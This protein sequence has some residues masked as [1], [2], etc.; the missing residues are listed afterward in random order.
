MR[1]AQRAVRG[2]LGT[3]LCPPKGCMTTVISFSCRAPRMW[4]GGEGV[5]RLRW[6][7]GRERTK[8][9]NPELLP[10]RDTGGGFFLGGFHIGPTFGKRAIGRQEDVFSC[11][12]DTGCELCPQ[13]RDALSASR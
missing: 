5:R 11:I 9:G 8:L 6:T 2:F 1:Q 12:V 4:E 10:H 13:I 3:P 7:L